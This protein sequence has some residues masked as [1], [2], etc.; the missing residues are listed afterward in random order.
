MFNVQNSKY[1]NFFFK[2]ENDSMSKSIL[3]L[4][5]KSKTIKEM[6]FIHDN[7]EMNKRIIKKVNY[8]Y[9]FKEFNLNC[10]KSSRKITNRYLI[11]LS[12]ELYKNYKNRFYSRN[13]TF[14]KKCLH[15]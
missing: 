14:Y 3:P 13:I 2:N 15:L 4:M 10:K 1:I 12:E 6:N 5:K 7:E 8:N 9:I 11:N